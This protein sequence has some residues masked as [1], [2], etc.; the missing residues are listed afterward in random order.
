MNSLLQA[1]VV[2]EDTTE[3]RRHTY[4]PMLLNFDDYRVP[5]RSGSGS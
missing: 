2:F 4:V 3:H 5:G 1:R